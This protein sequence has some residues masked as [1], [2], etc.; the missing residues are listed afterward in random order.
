MQ[1]RFSSKSGKSKRSGRT[2]ALVQEIIDEEMELEML[3]EDAETAESEADSRA[4]E[5]KAEA[6]RLDAVIK[7]RSSAVSS[8][9]S[10]RH[11]WS[12]AKKSVTTTWIATAGDRTWYLLH[13][14][15]RIWETSGG[16][17]G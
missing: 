8:V 10:Y 12:H 7:S 16:G 3:Q 4:F 9:P 1:L 5:A 17:S 14:H 11:S 13:Q 6:D 15:C 2:M